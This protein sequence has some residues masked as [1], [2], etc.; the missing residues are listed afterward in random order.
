MSEKISRVVIIDLDIE[1]GQLLV[2]GLAEAGVEDVTLIKDG[3]NLLNRILAIDPEV[4]LIDLENPR[5]D[6]VEQMLRVS[7]QVKRPVVMFADESEPELIRK[8][9]KAGVSAYIVDGVHTSRLKSILEI[10]VAQ[11]E[12]FSQVELEVVRLQ[13]ELDDRKTIDQ[14]KGILMNSRGLSE[15]EA[16]ALMRKASMNEKKKIS[17][18]A[19][20][21]VSASR[22]GL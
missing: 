13:Q 16:Y 12:R 22:I 6:T 2:E 17:E 4:I 14:A 10:A 7:E 3:N 20:L 1:R 18:I 5:R 9:V 21:L 11:F 8:A 19:Q 15:K